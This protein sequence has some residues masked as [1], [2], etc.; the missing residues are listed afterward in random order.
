MAAPEAHLT[1]AIV[2]F[3]STIIYLIWLFGF[4]ANKRPYQRM[5]LFCAIAIQ[6]ILTM[7]Y[8]FLYINLGTWVRMGDG[9]EIAPT[10]YFWYLIIFTL[11]FTY[12]TVNALR[13]DL[14]AASVAHF[15][16]LITTIITFFCTMI[17]YSA[18]RWTVFGFQAVLFIMSTF[19]LVS[20]FRRWAKH[21]DAWTLSIIVVTP[22]A[23][24]VYELIWIMGS[25]INVPGGGFISFRAAEWALFALDFV[26]LCIWVGYVVCDTGEGYNARG[27]KSEGVFVPKE[28]QSGDTV[29]VYET[30]AYPNN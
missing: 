14:H 19:F 16:A 15:S 26:V 7:M 12:I 10:R 25:V 28:N 6:L 11:P 1:G 3:I 4:T 23:L 29:T 27:Y 5:P 17:D 30:T 18:Q 2:F 8:T 24:V 9:V 22:L 21:M 20:F 13:Y